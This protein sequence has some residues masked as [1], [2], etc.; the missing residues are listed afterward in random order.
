MSPKVPTNW[1][2][3]VAPSASQQSSTSHRLYFLHSAVTTSRLNGLPRLWASMM[4]LVLGV[5]AASILLAS[6]LCVARSTSTNTGTAPNCTIGFTVVGKPAATPMTSSPCLIARSPSFGLVSAENAT[7]LADE[8]E[9]TVIR[10][11][12]PRN[13]ARRCS[14]IALKRPVVSQP[15]SEASTIIFSSPAPMTLPDTGTGVWPGTKALG[16]YAMSA[17]CWTSSL[18]WLRSLSSCGWKLTVEVVIR[19]IGIERFDSGRWRAC[20]GPRAR[21]DANR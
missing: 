4:A 16:A 11:F 1:P 10:Y 13:C 21:P 7:R 3:Y 8:P 2:L 19:R 5:M 6:M 18:I 15:S 17:Y 12:T 20:P 9:F 14:N